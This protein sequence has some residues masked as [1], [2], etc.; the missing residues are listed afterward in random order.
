MET[1]ECKD[2]PLHKSIEESEKQR[3]MDLA[4]AQ[5]WQDQLETNE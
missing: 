1:G 2:C 5:S 3:Q 4:T